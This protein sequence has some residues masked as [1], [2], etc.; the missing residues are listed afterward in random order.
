M[1]PTGPILAFQLTI[2]NFSE[3][4]ASPAYMVATPLHMS[5]C[6]GFGTVT[7]TGIISA[8]AQLLLLARTAVFAWWHKIFIAIYSDW[9][10][11]YT[12]YTNFPIQSVRQGY[13]VLK[14]PPCI[15]WL[16]N[17]NVMFKLFK[18][19]RF[20]NDTVKCTLATWAVSTC[21]FMP[22]CPREQLDS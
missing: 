8:G 9:P 1:H 2:P 4:L 18:V 20:F 15:D 16:V 22:A 13:R 11:W 21:M 17:T 3:A 6:A 7:Q 5:D 14:S 10:G 12:A 19:S